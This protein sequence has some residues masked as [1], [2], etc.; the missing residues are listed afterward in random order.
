MK[1]DIFVT[2]ERDAEMDTP[3]RS[4]TPTPEVTLKEGLKQTYS[5]FARQ[6]T[7]AAR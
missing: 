7:G 2:M 6:M 5:W 1:R 3:L 4:D